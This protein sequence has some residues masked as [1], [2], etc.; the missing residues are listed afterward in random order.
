MRLTD[1]T[2]N[3]QMIKSCSKDSV[4]IR[5]SELESNR[6]H[7]VKLIIIEERIKINFSSYL[8]TLTK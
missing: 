7:I 4:P 1:Y 5:I 8:K 6:Y 2:I 3:S